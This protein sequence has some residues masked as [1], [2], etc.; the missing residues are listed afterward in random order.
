MTQ[1]RH[2][3]EA[4]LHEDFEAIHYSNDIGLA[5]VNKPFILSSHTMFACLPE[6]A[7]DTQLPSPGQEQRSSF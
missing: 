6:P 2:I 1:S 5:K 3:V 7:A 4:Y